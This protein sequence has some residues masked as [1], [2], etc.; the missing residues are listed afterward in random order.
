MHASDLTDVHPLDAM[1][2]AFR[3]SSTTFYPSKFYSFAG[4]SVYQ[5]NN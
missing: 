1:L 4:Q 3:A 5:F 2:N